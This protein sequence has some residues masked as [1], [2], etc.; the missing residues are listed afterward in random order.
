VAIQQHRYRF[1]DAI[2]EVVTY[3]RHSHGTRLR[4]FLQVYLL[5]AF[6]PEVPNR[7]RDPGTR[8]P[9]PRLPLISSA[10]APPDA[11]VKYLK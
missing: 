6:V 3:P 1:N 11:N 10:I 2:P 5:G 7:Y 9:A 4:S 8:Y